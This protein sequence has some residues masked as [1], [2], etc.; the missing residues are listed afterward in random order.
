MLLSISLLLGLGACA[1]S[2][3][4]TGGTNN[5]TEKLSATPTIFPL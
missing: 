5:S 1:S 2:D 4:S 3:V